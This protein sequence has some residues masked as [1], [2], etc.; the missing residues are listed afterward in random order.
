M[1]I[2]TPLD[3]DY[4]AAFSIAVF[5]ACCAQF[6]ELNGCALVKEGD[7]ANIPF[8]E[9]VCNGT[10]EDVQLMLSAWH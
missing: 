5:K 2:Q 8:L 10:A 9:A 3:T 4:C 7:L 6:S 1:L